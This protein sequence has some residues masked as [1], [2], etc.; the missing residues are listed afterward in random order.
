MLQSD[1][2]VTRFVCSRGALIER[3]GMTPAESFARGA[4]GR[5][6]ITALRDQIRTYVREFLRPE[7]RLSARSRAFPK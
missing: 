2:N 6:A 3:V 4:H 1:I 5:D 7:V